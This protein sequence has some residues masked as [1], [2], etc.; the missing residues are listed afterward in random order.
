M[1]ET[2]AALDCGTNTL[3]LLVATTDETGRLVE[4]DRQLRFAGLGQGVDATG[5]F[6]DEAM[7]RGWAIVDEYLPVI[8]R[9]GATRA[10]FVATSAARDAS[11]RQVFFDGVRERLG[12][13][14]ELI[15]GQEE[16][17]LSFNGAISGART[18][19]DPVLVMD[20]GGGSTELV[21]GTAAGQISQSVSLDIGSRRVRERYLHSDPPTADQIT[22][23]RA[24]VNRMLDG[25]AVELGN[26]AT[27]IGVAGT[28]TTMVAL[29]LGL[30]QYDRASGA[31]LVDDCGAGGRACG[32]AARHDRG[33]GT[34]A[35]AGGSGAGEGVVRWGAGGGRGRQAGSRRSA[36][37][38]VRYSRWRR[39]V[40][41]ARW[42][43]SS[44]SPLNEPS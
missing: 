20:S 42:P 24:E 22:R 23:A 27:F 38:R 26:I 41:G 4:F 44:T 13:D 31:P 28:V 32:Q 35:R 10:R 43:G 2:V 33:R 25:C 6:A 34:G 14:P 1:A 29:H 12:I 5:Q 36:G 16:A 19:G 39:F 37:Q 11:N 21:H 15:S 9:L 18:D 17:Q 8:K 3:R 30:K 40:D 7:E